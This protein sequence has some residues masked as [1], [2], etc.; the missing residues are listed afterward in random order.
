MTGLSPA[1]YFPHLGAWAALT[2]FGAVEALLVL[3]WGYRAE[4][5]GHLLVVAVAI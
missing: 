3:A 5:G 1:R 4:F 2:G